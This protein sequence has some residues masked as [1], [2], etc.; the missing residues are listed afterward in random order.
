MGQKIFAGSERCFGAGARSIH[1][2]LSVEGVG[3]A[4][5]NQ[6]R[7]ASLSCSIDW[8]K[9]SISIVPVPT[10]L[11]WCSDHRSGVMTART[12]L[13]VLGSVLHFV[14]VSSRSCFISCAVA[15]SLHIILTRH[16]TRLL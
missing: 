4:L 3:R 12:A 2:R 6:G 14:A 8:R 13:G 10:I 9:V 1:F 11:N 16:S 15:V 7:A 5:T